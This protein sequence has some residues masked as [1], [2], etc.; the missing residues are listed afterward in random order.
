MKVTSG[1]KYSCTYPAHT[2]MCMCHINGQSCVCCISAVS[3]CEWGSTSLKASEIPPAM[4]NKTL[5]KNECHITI[6]YPASMSSL[7]A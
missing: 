7:N 6:S 1:S 4:R 5:G 3:M 2:G